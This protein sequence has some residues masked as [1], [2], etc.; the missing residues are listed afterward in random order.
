MPGGAYINAPLVGN[1]M[2]SWTVVQGTGLGYCEVG[3]T[4][5][6]LKATTV[7]ADFLYS[8]R[9]EGG[10]WTIRDSGVVL[11]TLVLGAAS[12]PRILHDG[13]TIKFYIGNTLRW[14]IIMT[15]EGQ[16]LYAKNLNEGD[17]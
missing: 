7:S 15:T 16:T 17:S 2:V 10:N 9:F 11:S 6:A 13:K 5:S 12:I 14:T 8:M 4:T 1:G 3:F